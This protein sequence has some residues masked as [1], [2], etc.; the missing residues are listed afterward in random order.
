[1]RF[2]DASAFS[3]SE[4]E[5][6]S[7]SRAAPRASKTTF[8]CFARSRSSRRGAR[9]SPSTHSRTYFSGTLPRHVAFAPGDTTSRPSSLRIS[10]S[11]AQCSAS[12][13]F[14]AKSS[15]KTEIAAAA[16]AGSAAASRA[17]RIVFIGKGSIGC[18]GG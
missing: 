12:V 17:G 10:P 14:V 7:M 2:G 5:T 18:E 11:A 13:W 6:S 3:G 15:E 4:T 8:G 16:D 9:S 1:M